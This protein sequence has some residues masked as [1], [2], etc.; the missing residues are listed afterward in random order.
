MNEITM[1]SI[2]VNN[3][4]LSEKTIELI[5][6]MNGHSKKVYEDILFAVTGY[7]DYN[8]YLDDNI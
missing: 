2:L 1:K 8:K 6:K 3:I 4:G 7:S 5:V